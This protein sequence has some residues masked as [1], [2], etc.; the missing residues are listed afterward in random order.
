MIFDFRLLIFDCNTETHSP[1]GN[2]K[3]KKETASL[4]ASPPVRQLLCHSLEDIFPAA[5]FCLPEEAH[6]GIPGTIFTLEQPAPIGG[7]G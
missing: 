2:R 6:R 1:I 4:F 7:H 3:S 5:V